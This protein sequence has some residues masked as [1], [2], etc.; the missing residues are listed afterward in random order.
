MKGDDYELRG[1]SLNEDT[2]RG[3][4]REPLAFLSPEQSSNEPNLLR[5]MLYIVGNQGVTG[6][7]PPV[8]KQITA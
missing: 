4:K 6:I 2:N 7:Y 8:F 3:V 1:G 5:L